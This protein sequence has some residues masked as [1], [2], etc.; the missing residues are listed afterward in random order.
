MNQEIGMV[1]EI[2][3]T[4]CRHDERMPNSTEIM[5]L[6]DVAAKVATDQ[7]DEEIRRLKGLIEDAR[8]SFDECSAQCASMLRDIHKVT[9]T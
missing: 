2:I 4:A 7:K 9:N 8:R 1:W 5:R 3:E 6:C